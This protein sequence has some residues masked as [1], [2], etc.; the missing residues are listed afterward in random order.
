MLCSGKRITF[1]NTPFFKSTK[2][3]HVLF[4]TSFNDTDCLHDE[5]NN[6]DNEDSSELVRSWGSDETGPISPPLPKLKPS[7]SKLPFNVPKTKKN[8]TE[9]YSDIKRMINTQ[10][11]SYKPL[12]GIYQNQK[13]I[14]LN[15][16][17]DKR[18]LII[19]V[20]KLVGST[21]LSS[22]LSPASRKLMSLESKYKVTTA[23]LK[24]WHAKNC[25]GGSMKV[26]DV[27][28]K[29]NVNVSTITFLGK[30]SESERR[31]YKTNINE[32]LKNRET[33]TTRDYALPEIKNEGFNLT[34]I[35]NKIPCYTI[36]PNGTKSSSIK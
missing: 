36:P 13:Y 35:R 10:T 30:F 25:S 29:A 18:R 31:L 34:S 11:Y 4:C 16:T 5:A 20:N 8:K 33:T 12:N 26:N 3:V 19:P 22:K 32:R 9:V 15:H 17:P 27:R 2:H 6:F 23:D 7:I 1:Q 14:K 28:M 21:M 24:N